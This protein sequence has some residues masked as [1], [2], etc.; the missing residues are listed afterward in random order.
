MVLLPDAPDEGESE[1]GTPPTSGNKDSLKRKQ[2][3]SDGDGEQNQRKT[4]AKR[5]DY[6]YLS[7]PFPDEEENE[8]TYSSEQLYAIIAGDD[9][10]SL[11]EARDSPDWP[12]WEKAIQSEL[13]QLCQMGT[14]KLVKKP[15]HAI[16]IANRWRF[17]RKRN[18]AGEVIRFKARLVAKGYKGLVMTM[19]RLF[20]Q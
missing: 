11:K 12:E 1:G 8:I 18:K 17:V 10:N 9:L 5:V 13:N 19:P 4:R 2:D 3:K 15:P 14:W 20:P 6:R 7:N 16:P